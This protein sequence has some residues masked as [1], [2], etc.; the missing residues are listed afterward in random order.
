[1]YRQTKVDGQQRCEDDSSPNTGERTKAAGAKANQ[2]K[3]KRRCRAH[4]ASPAS[5]TIGS[6]RFASASESKTAPTDPKTTTMATSINNG[7]PSCP[8]REPSTNA[9][10]G[11]TKV[12]VES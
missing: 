1:M 7:T 6:W 3:H 9:M 10:I 4:S 12:N 8:N 2:Q 5:K 11:T